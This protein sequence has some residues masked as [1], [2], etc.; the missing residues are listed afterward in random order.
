M[1]GVVQALLALRALPTRARA[2]ARPRARTG[3]GL[4]NRLKL[5]RRMK[6]SLGHQ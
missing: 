1:V 5:V 6:A 3:V 2:R 4:Q